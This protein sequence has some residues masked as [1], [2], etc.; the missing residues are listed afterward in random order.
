[1][2]ISAE[3]KEK[4]ASKQSSM[5]RA[6]F[7]AGQELKK[8]F[9]QDAV[10]DF[11]LGNPDLQ[12]PQEVLDAIGDVF[13]EEIPGCH[14]YMTNAGYETTRAAIARKVSAEQ[15]CPVSAKNVVMSCGAAG[16]LNTVFRGILNPGD[17][18][19]V[20]APFF[21]E[22]AQYCGNYGGKLV[23]VDCRE[24]F[25]PDI[26]AMERAITDKTVAVIVNSPNNPTGA[27]YSDADMVGLVAVLKR[28]GR[29]LWL[30]ADEPYRDI[31][32]DGAKVATLFDKYSHSVIVS[33]FAKNFGLP[34]ERLGFVAAN[35]AAKEDGDELVA[36]V[37]F[38]T[39]SLG[40]VNA[41]AFFQRVIE[42]AVDAKTDFSVY[43]K[44]RAALMKILDDCGFEYLRPKGAFY[45]FCK[46]PDG[47]DDVEFCDLLKSHRILAVP[48]VAFGKRGYFRLAYCVS[49][50]VIVSSE[51]AF[52]E[53]AATLNVGN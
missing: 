17:E 1:M 52:K 49:E 2:A 40:F 22:Y 25:S 38:A 50:Q 29:N 28:T 23:P 24:D 15:G 27:V 3:I 32:Y 13:R 34:G 44:R 6:M 53:V 21:A 37:I 48:G 19:L 46:V 31:L 39:R 45:I 41:P 8:Q 30:I 12:P 36:A 51:K 16:G 10:F 11:S 42:K 26:E 4:L 7:E 33:S 20:S 35:P 9:G 14:G 18:I 5:I 47:G 43:E